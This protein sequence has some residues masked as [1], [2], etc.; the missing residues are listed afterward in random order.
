MEGRGFLIEDNKA[1]AT[2]SQD[3]KLEPAVPNE[4]QENMHNN[5]QEKNREQIPNK[6]NP[7]LCIAH[8]SQ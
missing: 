5:K 2:N 8:F 4:I 1:Q 3:K 7:G 6:V